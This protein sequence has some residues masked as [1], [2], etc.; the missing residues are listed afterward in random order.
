[1]QMAI[2]YMYVC[3]FC[4]MCMCMYVCSFW[5]LNAFCCLIDLS[6]STQIWVDS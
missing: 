1:M 3:S 6:V 2:V 5:V 4:A